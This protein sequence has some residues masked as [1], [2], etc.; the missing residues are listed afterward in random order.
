MDN[1]IIEE[2]KKMLIISGN[3]SDFQLENLKKWGFILFDGLKS[4]TI[5][6][7]FSSDKANQIISEGTVEFD[8]IFDKDTVIEN[9]DK[10]I[11]QLTTWTRFLFWV[12]T[13]VVVKKNGE[14]WV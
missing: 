11:E 9:K 12:E 4:V 1:N 7:D 5:N 10:K 13:K 14:I 8:F 2:H 6:Y 3:L